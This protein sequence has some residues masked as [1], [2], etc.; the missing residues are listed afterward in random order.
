MRIED[1]V[2]VMKFTNDWHKF[3]V[4]ILFTSSWLSLSSEKRAVKSD[5]TLQ[6]FN[7]LRIQSGQLPKPTT[8]KLLRSCMMNNTPIFIF[9]TVGS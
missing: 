6:C 5:N 2:K 8:N 9:N 3:T 4:N 1:E 7:A